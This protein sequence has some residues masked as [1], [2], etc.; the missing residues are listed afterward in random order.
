MTAKNSTAA[1]EETTEVANV[2]KAELSVA[3]NFYE[4]AGK[5][6]ENLDKDSVAI[7]FLAVLQGL[8]PQIESVA[9]AKPG[10]IINTVTNEM[11]NEIRL[12]PCAFQRKFL[13]WV[14]RTAG[15]GFKGELDVVEYE[16]LKISGKIVEKQ[17]EKGSIVEMLGND[18]VKDTRIHFVLCE[19]DGILTPAVLSLGSTQI[20]VSKRLMAMIS[21]IQIKGPNGKPF[22]PP[23]FSHIYRFGTEKVSNE[24]GTWY[25]FKIIGSDPISD[26]YL[27]GEAKKFNAQV[28][29][30]AAVVNHADS[31]MQ[32]QFAEQGEAEDNNF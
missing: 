25:I 7:P 8:S 3:I 14:P 11:F 9:G 1:K 30:G 32:E 27:Y 5:G 28:M 4:D 26:P 2:E 19:R 18:E 22:N 23:S 29:S 16:K 12:I 15:G 24:K 21:G 10:L 31:V 13:K 20:K 17:T 6:T